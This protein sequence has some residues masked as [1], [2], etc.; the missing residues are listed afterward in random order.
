MPKMPQKLLDEKFM[1]LNSKNSRKV[2]D[3]QEEQ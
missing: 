3:T 2:H 1:S